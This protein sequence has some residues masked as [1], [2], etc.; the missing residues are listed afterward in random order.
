MPNRNIIKIRKKLDKLDNIFLNLIKQRLILVKEVLK[1]KKYKKEI[2]D[3]E[4]IKIIL[5]NIAKKSKQ[6]KIDPKITNKIWNSMIKSF[7][8]FEYRNFKKK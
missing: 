6:K 3:K 7:I 8:D 5:K 2:V 1:N 4:R